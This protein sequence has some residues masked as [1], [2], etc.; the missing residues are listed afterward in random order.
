MNNPIKW[1]IKALIQN[2]ISFAPFS[3]Q[4]NYFLQKYLSGAFSPDEMIQSYK[5]Q[6]KQIDLLNRRESINNK[7]I[8][9]IGPGWFSIS[10]LIFWLLKSKSI[11]WVDTRRNFHLDLTKNY[12]KALLSIKEEVSND[13]NI[14]IHELQEKLEQVCKCESDSDFFKLCSITYDAPGDACSINL[15]NKSVDLI[16]SWGVLEHI[17]WPDL[18][19]IFENSQS[20]LSDNGR[21]YHNIGMHDHFHSAGLG[22]G[23]N[24]LRY[25]NFEWRI[26]AGNQFAYHNRKRGVDYLKLIKENN[27]KITYKWEEFLDLNLD[28]VDSINIHPDF[29]S[30][31]K[32]ELACSHLLVECII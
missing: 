13:I 6:I 11:Y 21:H 2:L 20:L 27:F 31:T 16:Y 7:K 14:S 24:F 12:A 32:K 15:E 17:P 4:L 19:K 30:Y 9:E 18:C 1:K 10:G 5:V 29:S 26:I 22:N 28:A 3:V 8:L 25:S 23:V